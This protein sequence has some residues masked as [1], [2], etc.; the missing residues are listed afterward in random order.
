MCKAG[1]Y[2]SVS[3]NGAGDLKAHMDTKKH[4]KTVVRALLQ[5]SLL[6][7]ETG[8]AVNAAEGA[9]T[10]HSVKHHNRSMDYTSS[11]LKKKKILFCGSNHGAVK[12][13]P[14]IIQYFD[15]KKGGVRRKNVFAN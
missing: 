5:S 4:K 6:N 9:M 12:I 15:W 11:L 2:F 3:N 13:F 10:F 7:R 1:T 8:D 14:I